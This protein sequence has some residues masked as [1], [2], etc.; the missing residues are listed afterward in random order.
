MVILNLSLHLFYYVF[1]ENGNAKRL[2]TPISAAGEEG[3]HGT[4]VPK[5][6]GRI[7]TLLRI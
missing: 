3:C 2:A 1:E 5:E 7:A 6:L 4:H